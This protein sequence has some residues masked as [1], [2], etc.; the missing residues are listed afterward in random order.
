MSKK[1]FLTGG[2]GN[3]GKKILNLKTK[4]KILHPSKLEVDILN[5]RK[6][7][8]FIKKNKP[9]YILHLA[10]LSDPMAQH[11]KKKME[12]IKKNIIGTA[13]LCLAAEKFKIKMIYTSTNFVY[14]GNNGNFSEEQPLLPFNN[15]GWSKLGGE[16]S[17]MMLKKFLILRLCLAKT[18]FKHKFAFTNYITSFLSDHLV[19]EIIL[20][21]IDQKGIIN[22]GGKKQSSYNF[23]INEG[24]KVIGKKLKK[25]N[26][27]K[28]GK[29]TSINTNKLNK[30]IKLK[31]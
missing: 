13:N 21:L 17:V 5:L 29:N 14:P 26:S 18:P 27:Y 16:C 10:G 31:I 2:S 11:E 9:K 28:I 4:Y 8:S 30:I 24:Y 12:S 22:I 23:A 3:L 19:A 7:E 15:Y 25:K 1:I 6:I 20:K